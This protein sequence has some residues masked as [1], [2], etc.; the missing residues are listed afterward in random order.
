MSQD[1]R[2]R[3]ARKT[4]LA[5]LFAATGYSLA[6]LRR[7]LRE[8][9]F[10]HELV[11]GAGLGLVFALLGKPLW[12]FAGLAVLILLVLAV[13]TLNTAIETLVDHLSPGWSEF[14]RD[15]KDLGSLAVMCLLIAV[16]VFALWVLV[17]A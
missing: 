15:A 17:A 3:P 6:G 7:M 12:A 2:P 16:G 5:H 11:A 9:A 1:N 8:T 10:R 4:G 14:A 13:E